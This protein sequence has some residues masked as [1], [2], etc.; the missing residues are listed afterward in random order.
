MNSNLKE[1]SQAGV[2][3]PFPHAKDRATRLEMHEATFN[4]RDVELELLVPQKA[5]T[6]SLVDIY[7]TQFEQIH[8]V[9]HIPSFRRSYDMYFDAVS[10]VRN[11]ALTA[12]VL[13]IISV[14]CSMYSTEKLAYINDNEPSRST[15]A[16]EKWIAAVEE[17]SGKQSQKHRRLIHYQ[18]LCLTHLAKRVHLIKKK[19][20]W[21]DACALTQEAIAL[22][23]HRELILMNGRTGAFISEMRRRL[24]STIQEF[25]LQTSF[26]NGLPSP[27]SM[28]SIEVQAPSNINDDE[29][30]EDVEELPQ[31]RPE[32]TYTFSSYQHISAKSLSLRLELSSKLTGPITEMD[33]DTV[34]RLTGEVSREIDALPSWEASE[35]NTQE[36]KNPIPSYAMLHLSLRQWLI[37]MHQ[38]FLKLRK[39]NPKYSYSENVYFSAVSD[40]VRIHETCSRNGPGLPN[41]LREDTLMLTV[42]SICSVVVLQP[43]GI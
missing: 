18:I 43:R 5:L 12:L 8:R 41:Y 11:S 40:L 29:F 28:V 39:E 38:P 7:L 35:E 34:T 22:G 6:D 26:M 15:E 25:S 30:D 20:F 42:V 14:S 24:F 27:L 31:S 2:K 23:L 37:I 17:W 19:R 4:Q 1:L 21:T 36:S 10:P 9:V 16:A 32:T 3:N 33:Y 13:S